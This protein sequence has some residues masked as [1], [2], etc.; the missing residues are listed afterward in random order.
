MFSLFQNDHS[1]PLSPSFLLSQ[2]EGR[3]KKKQTFRLKPYDDEEERSTMITIVRLS[4]DFIQYSP[5]GDN[6][7]NLLTSKYLP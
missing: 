4:M 7:E 5:R 2:E 1:K 3:E 6:V